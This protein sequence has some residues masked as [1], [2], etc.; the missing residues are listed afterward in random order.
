MARGHLEPGYTNLCVQFE[1]EPR[2]HGWGPG[3]FVYAVLR[4]S[5]KHWDKVRDIIGRLD[6]I[7]GIESIHTILYHAEC[8]ALT[9]K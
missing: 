9:T 5:A 4:D 8:S 6:P 3:P 2:V 7:V 1:E